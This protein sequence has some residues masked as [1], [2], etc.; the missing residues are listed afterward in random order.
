MPN[1]ESK[2][3]N[4]LG[5]QAPVNNGLSSNSLE[6]T[7]ILL[8]HNRHKM[9]VEAIESIA[10]QTNSSFILIVSDSSDDDS[11]GDVVRKRFP[12]AI[13]RKRSSSLSA[14]EHGNLCISEV[15][16]PYFV[17]FHD[18]DLMLPNFVQEFRGA[19]ARYP[20]VAA[21]GCNALIER[22]GIICH[23]SFKCLA[24]Y[25]GP[26]DS[27]GLAQ[28]YFSRHQMGIAPLP[29]YIYQTKFVGKTRIDLAGGKYGDVQWLMEVAKSGRLVWI[30]RPTMIYRLHDGNDSNAESIRDR[31]RF[32]GFLK[33]HREL[34]SQGLIRDYRNL[35]YKKIDRDLLTASRK[36]TIDAY[37][38]SYKV[39]RL[40]RFDHHKALL[41]KMRIKFAHLGR[42]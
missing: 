42:Y 14:I 25:E 33:R 40:F 20:E 8:T 29:S 19:Q 17:L 5:L 7:I 9:A 2:L 1:I 10:K 27:L 4:P 38:K 22:R 37:L 30:A 41:K 23:P 13:Y 3:N 16:T 31:L 32:L 24:S 21:F 34:C 6:L 18:D 36:E 26:I 39:M 15:Q 28:R 12:S 11:L 35:L